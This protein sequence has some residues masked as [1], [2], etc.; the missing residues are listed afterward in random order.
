MA[1]A[2]NTTNPSP[3]C[4][5]RA[6]CNAAPQSPGCLYPACD[7]TKLPRAAQPVPSDGKTSTLASA[8]RAGA[9]RPR[10]RCTVTLTLPKAVTEALGNLR[11]AIPLAFGQPAQPQLHYMVEVDHRRGTF[12]VQHSIATGSGA[13]ITG[14]LWLPPDEAE[15]LAQALLLAVTDWRADEAAAA[16]TTARGEVAR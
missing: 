10:R 1:V 2:D 11:P 16:W 9:G 12:G 5:I 3:R 4:A 8:V 14:A 13:R 6:A 15:A 7:C